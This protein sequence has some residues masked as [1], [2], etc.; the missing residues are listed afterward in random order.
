VSA[1]SYPER[2]RQMARI[3]VPSGAYK[4]ANV[5]WTP[6]LPYIHYGRLPVLELGMLDAVHHALEQLFDWVLTMTMM[7]SS[8]RVM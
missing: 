5:V 8:D 4:L 7:S 6:T 2:Y 3:E 1:N